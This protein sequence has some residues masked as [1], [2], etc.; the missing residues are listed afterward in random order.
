[1]DFFLTYPDNQQSEIINHLQQTIKYKE[2]RN[3]PFDNF[4]RWEKH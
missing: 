4:E 2:V 1:M 3:V